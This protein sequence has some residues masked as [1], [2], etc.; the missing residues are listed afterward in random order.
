MRVEDPQSCRES[1]QF[2]FLMND[3]S[4]LLGGILISTLSDSA[5]QATQIH[6]G[7]LH[8]VFL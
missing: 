8:Y 7:Q 5:L 4:I 1:A 6:T 2:W 3:W